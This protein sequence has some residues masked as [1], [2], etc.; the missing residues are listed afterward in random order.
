MLIKGFDVRTVKDAFAKGDELTISIDKNDYKVGEALSVET[1][2][3]QVIGNVTWSF[4]H[5]VKIKMT[6]LINKEING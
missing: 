2:K 4:E 3:L 5:L 1:D 6:K